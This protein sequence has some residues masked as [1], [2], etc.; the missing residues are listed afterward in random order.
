M[1]VVR[2]CERENIIK[3]VLMELNDRLAMRSKDKKEE[4]DVGFMF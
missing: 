2:R 4:M 1:S 3:K